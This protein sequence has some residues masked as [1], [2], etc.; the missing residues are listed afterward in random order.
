MTTSNVKHHSLNP[1]EGKDELKLKKSGFSSVSEKIE[2]KIISETEDFLQLQ[3]QWDELASLSEATIFQTFIWNKTWWKHFGTNKK[4]CI[5]TLYDEDSL[6][7]I[8]PSFIDTIEYSGRKLYSSLRLLG[9]SVSQPKGEDL[10]GLKA[11]SDYMD[12]IVQPG[13]EKIF[14]SRLA[15]FFINN[16]LNIHEIVLEEV[17]AESAVCS[18]LL[19][20][21]EQK[22]ISYTEKKQSVCPV[23]KLEN[24]WEEY[25]KT[26]SKRRRNHVRKFI[27]KVYD[28]EIKI[29][30][31]ERAD[32]ADQVSSAFEKLVT[33]HQN[34]WNSLGYPGVFAE[35][36][37]HNFLKEAISLL[38]EEGCTWINIISSTK[39]KQIAAIDLLFVYKDKL[40]LLQR[41]YD[42]ASDVHEE[43]PGTVLLYNTI[44]EGVEKNYKFFDFLRGEDKYKYR[45]ANISMENKL[46][47][48]T[49]VGLPLRIH[50]RIVKKLPAAKRKIRQESDKF[51]LV[52]R[53]KS[54]LVGIR[55]Y[56]KFVYKRIQ[57]QQR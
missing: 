9:T 56:I 48:I 25:L 2:L 19:P 51:R 8:F 20:R 18:F 1:S 28:P 17:P 10:K 39:K 36:R 27:R 6:A 22:G 24:S 40:Y 21:L 53:D 49:S 38:F 34:H 45:T 23:A 57:Y 15:D 47:Q 54:F 31:L 55:D 29:F 50:H 13:Y 14:A 16:S 37:Y 26:M 35:K 4:L 12:I 11:Y 33:L 32:T 43:S 7:G 3:K 44:Q 46:I 30:D 41:A 42:S 5:I 52:I